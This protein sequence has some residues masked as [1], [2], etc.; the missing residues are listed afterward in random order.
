MTPKPVELVI[1]IAFS[2]SAVLANRACAEGQLLYGM[3]VAIEPDPVTGLVYRF[4]PEQTA[5]ENALTGKLISDALARERRKLAELDPR[6]ADRSQVL[7]SIANLVRAEQVFRIQSLCGSE[8]HSQP[9]EQYDGNL[10]PTK[11]F[12]AGTQQAT[13]QLQWNE[14]LVKVFSKANDNP[15]TVSG[16]RWCTGSLIDKNHVLTAGH[17]FDPDVNGFIT[18]R[19]FIRGAVTRLQ[20]FGLAPLMHVNFNYQIDGRTNQPRPEVSY[21]IARLI[22]YEQGGLDYA[23]AE[24]G[25]GSDRK[26]AGDRFSPISHDSSDKEL[27]DA[28]LL[29]V[30]QHP[31]QEPKR[32]SAGSR[33]P[34][35]GKS[36]QYGDVDTL[37]GS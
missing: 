27:A 31:H 26:D 4:D 16:R 25:V 14:N 32:I 30:I 37:D 29:T 34:F 36:I 15:G 11:D 8:D 23:I 19:R 21:P 20:P 7:K 33:I 9:V 24:L 6:S 13:L 12:V 18:P 10:G 35:S 1:A 28:R 17:C 5:Q 22:E 2:L 3:P